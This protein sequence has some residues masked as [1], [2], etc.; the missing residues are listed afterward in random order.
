MSHGQFVV[1]YET[2]PLG[3]LISTPKTLRI[4][5]VH[6]IRDTRFQL[7]LINWACTLLASLGVS[8]CGLSMMPMFPAVG[9]DAER[10]FLFLFVLCIGAGDFLLDFA[11][12]DKR[13]F[14][15]ATR[16]HALSIFEDRELSLP[17]PVN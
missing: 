12:E 6:K 5:L 9:V 14:E 1:A 13:F 2:V 15:L 11:V 16:R 7:L 10:V 17:Q 8:I 4:L 3:F